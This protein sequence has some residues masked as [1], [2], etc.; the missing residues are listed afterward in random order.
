[1]S[2][3][4]VSQIQ[5]SAN[6]LI[7][8]LYIVIGLNGALA[9]FLGSYSILS[10]S[11]LSVFCI[12]TD[13]VLRVILISSIRVIKCCSVSLNLFFIHPHIAAHNLARGNCASGLRFLAHSQHI[14]VS[15]LTSESKFIQ[16]INEPRAFYPEYYVPQTLMHKDLGLCVIEQQKVLSLHSYVRTS[17]FPIPCKTILHALQDFT[18]S[19]RGVGKVLIRI[20][21][22]LFRE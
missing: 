8:S 19:A 17:I 18:F 10:G 5:I 7:L 14:L 4:I 3:Q 15:I 1:M 12:Y 6:V 2:L 11:Q 21:N 13:K 16:F 20:K 9:P 22:T